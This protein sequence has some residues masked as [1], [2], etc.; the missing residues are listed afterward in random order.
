MTRVLRRASVLA[1]LSALV[2]PA[3]ATA[4]TYC[5]GEPACV[6]AGGEEAGGAEGSAL[7]HA[8]ELAQTHAG[9]TVVIGQ[10]SYVRAGGFSY[11]GPAVTIR[12][13][14]TTATQLT[15]SSKTGTVLNLSAAAGTGPTLSGVGIVIP[16]AESQNGLSLSGAASA[17]GVAVSGG[18]GSAM[19][20]GVTLSAGTRFAYGSV[21]LLAPSTGVNF[22]S[23][24]EALYDS[25]SANYG[26]QGSGAET[27]RGCKVFATLYGILGYYAAIVAEDTLIDMQG[28]GVAGVLVAANVNGNAS[29]SLRHVTIV[30]GGSATVGLLVQAEEVKG[31]AVSSFVEMANTVIAGIGHAIAQNDAGANAGT[32]VGTTYSDYEPGTNQRTFSEGAKQPKEPLAEAMVFGD[33]KF[34]HQINM[35]KEAGS[36]ALADYRLSPGS[37]LIDAGS[38]VAIEEG[39]LATDLGG[40]PRIV[41]GRRDVGAY[42]FQWRPAVLSISAT[43]ATVFVG[44]PVTFSGALAITEA[45]DTAG[46]S[47]WA[48]GDGTEAAE[49]PFRHSYSTPGTYTTTLSWTDLMGLTVSASTQVRV[50]APPPAGGLTCA[51]GGMCKSTVTSPAVTALSLSPRRFR[52]RS[53]DWTLVT[54]TLS[55]GATVTF[56]AERVLAGTLHRRTCTAPRHRLRGPRCLR[57]AR[58]GS[59]TR[60]GSGG[61]SAFRF[62]GRINGRPLPAGSYVLIASLADGSTLRA[63]FTIL[64]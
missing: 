40:N 64:K 43:P 1:V 48:F 23:G 30:D 62:S 58:Y 53:H 29:G 24:G 54:V 60:A 39:E 27:I 28:G 38:P 4:N 12:G 3:A 45:G 52:A 44:E 5:V 59:F 56:T 35:S 34:L 16:A 26:V 63:P 51:P 25:I 6:A 61:E 18:G 15:D 9:S 41:H 31:K 8:L 22:V 13:A 50:L 32:G 36:A 57:L 42:E 33:P 2:L 10:G 14:G 55:K 21:S 19:A 37:P 7:Q 11:S 49:V 47:H 17:E 20:T 46:V